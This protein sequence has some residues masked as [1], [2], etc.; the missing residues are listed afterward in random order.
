[1]RFAGPVITSTAFRRW[2]AKADCG[3]GVA[4]AR[5]RQEFAVLLRDAG[6]IAL[7]AVADPGLTM[8]RRTISHLSAKGLGD[9]A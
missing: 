5:G 1:V 9:P 3:V 8:F 6:Q 2:A 4:G 7:G